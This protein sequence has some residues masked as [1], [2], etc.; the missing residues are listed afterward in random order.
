MTD[1]PTVVEIPFGT[2]TGQI[3]VGT[4]REARS[5]DIAVLLTVG[6][7][8]MV[9]TIEGAREL[10]DGLAGEAAYAAVVASKA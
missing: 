2:D 6:P 5:G 8:R 1:P 10:A 3:Q 7:V 9:L 4:V